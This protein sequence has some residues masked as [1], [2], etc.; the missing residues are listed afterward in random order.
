MRYKYGTFSQDQVI[1]SKEKMRKSIFFLLLIADPKTKNEYNN[2]DVN[3]AFKNLLYRLGGFNSMLEGEPKLIIVMSLLERALL[4]YNSTK[5][6]FSIYRKLIL[7]AG[8]EVQ[9]IE[10][11]D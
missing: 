3:N 11:V 1:W 9:K 4:E 6:D 7:D 2:I 8:A 5:F 10:E